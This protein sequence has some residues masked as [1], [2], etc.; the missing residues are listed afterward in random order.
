MSII[1]DETTIENAAKEFLHAVEGYVVFAFTG[2]LGAGKTTFI[3]AVCKVLGVA[4]AVSSPTYA[5]IQEYETGAARLIYHLDLY[6][7]K[8]E[9]EALEAG[10]EDCVNSGDLCFVEWPERAPGI[11]SPD[12]VFCTLEFLNHRQRKLIVQMPEIQ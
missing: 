9:N 8:D 11:F 3:N 6:R 12:T 5:I 2:N 7:L 10:I 4:E 1:F